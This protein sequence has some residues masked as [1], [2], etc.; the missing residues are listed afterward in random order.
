MWW[1]YLKKHL[2]FQN[3]ILKLHPDEY[4][5]GY[6]GNQPFVLT[7]EWCIITWIVVPG[8]TI[9]V[10]KNMAAI[11]STSGCTSLHFLTIEL[12]SSS[13]GEKN[14]QTEY[15]SLVA[16]VVEDS[17]PCLS[18]VS[19]SAEPEAYGTCTG[20][21]PCTWWAV[22][23]Y[24]PVTVCPQGSAFSQAPPRWIGHEVHLE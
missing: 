19:Q 17:L 12:I 1:S 3:S 21:T 7:A 22:C 5:Y 10:K 24:S 13:W 15:G 14:A 9:D 6:R 11:Y 2:L 23:L 18:P 16:A 8:E 20:S 4:K